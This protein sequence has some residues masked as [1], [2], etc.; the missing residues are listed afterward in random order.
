MQ[1][2]LINLTFFEAWDRRE[3]LL[4][5]LALLNHLSEK[6]YDCS[7]VVSDPWFQTLATRSLDE[8]HEEASLCCA[9]IGQMDTCI[10]GHDYMAPTGKC[11]CILCENGLLQ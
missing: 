8:L 4:D 3:W 10:A 5:R 1:Y 7:K 6:M 11:E 2:R 9:A